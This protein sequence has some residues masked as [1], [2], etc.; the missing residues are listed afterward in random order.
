MTYIVLTNSDFWEDPPRARHQVAESLSRRHKV[1]FVST[2][3]LGPP[4]LS[5][6]HVTENLRVIVPRFPVDFRVRYRVSLVNR[7]YQHW[8]FRRLVERIG[9]QRTVVVNFDNTATEVYKYFR[10]VVY[11]CNDYSIRYYYLP[12]IRRY[13]ERCEEFVASRALFCVATCSFLADRLRRFNRDVLELRLGAPTVKG[14]LAFRRDGTVRVA[15]VGYLGYGRV[16]TGILSGLLASEKVELRVFGLVDGRLRKYLRSFRNVSLRGVVKGDGLVDQLK[17]VD[18]GIAPYRVE[19]VNQG[20]TPNKLWQ[21]LAVGKPVVVS[22]LPAMRDWRFPDR[23]VYR[24]NSAA[25]FVAAVFRAYEEDSERL[26]SARA[27]FAASNSWQQ[28]VDVLLTEIGARCYTPA[29]TVVSP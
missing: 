12:S 16:S 3:R 21:Y 26:M 10:H 13:F 25:E 23:F 7:A 9:D 2:N 11:Y 27:E 20:G 8:L 14:P 22:D 19:D 6:K 1:C 28:R 29:T 5:A 17:R 18:V 15:L 24:A 4:S